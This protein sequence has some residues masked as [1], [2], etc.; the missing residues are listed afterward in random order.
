MTAPPSSNQPAAARLWLFRLVAAMGLPLMVLLALE[1]GLRLGGYGRSASFLI[2][3]ER[4]GFFRSNPEY[5]KLF[6]PG[7]FDLRP[8]NFR[9]AVRKPAN[10]IRVVV[11]GES[12]AQGVP[13][14]LFGFAPQLRAQLR[15]R[16]PRKEIEVINTGI[17][18][19]NSH[20]VYQIACD[21][22][23]IDP[24]LFVVYLGNNEIVGPYGPGCSYLSEMPPLWTIRL[25]VF[26]RATRVGQLMGACLGQL[27]H[28]GMQAE[29]GGMTMF[30]DHAV[31]GDDPRLG[32]VYRNFEANLDDIIRVATAGGARTLLCTVVSNLKDCA[33]F[34]SQHRPGM[35]AADL[36]AWQRAFDRGRIEWRLDRPAKA[37]VSLQEAAQLDPTYADTLFMLGS[38]ALQAGETEN[39]RT[40]LVAAQHWDA[41]RFRP[42]TRI[43][44][45]IRQV[46]SN[47]TGEVRLLDAAVL[48]GS[49]PASTTP[50]AGRELLYEHVHLNWAGNYQ[51]ARL[52][53]EASESTLFGGPDAG[54]PAFLDS[55]G[56]AA[57]LAYS[58]REHHSVLGVVQGIVMAPPFT[59]QLTYCEDGARLVR[60]MAKART[61]SVDTLNLKRAKELVQSAI[62]HDPINPDL[63]KLEENINDALGDIPG[64]WAAVRRA[65]ELQ[66]YYY[67]LAVDEAI[68]LSRLERYGEA[69]NLLK[70]TAAAC[71]PRDLAA[72][73]Q[74]LADLY[75]RTRRWDEGR[76]F[77]DGMIARQPT[78]LKLR[79]IRGRLAHLAGD[80]KS[81]EREFRGIL[82]EE[83][84]N[85]LALESLVSLLNETGRK[86]AAIQASVE[87][88][89]RQPKNQV[90]NFRAALVMEERR[91]D[92]MAVKYYLAAEQSGPVDSAFEIHLAQKMFARGQ[93]DE[94]LLHLGNAKQ[95]S[96][97][98]EN[99]AGAETVERILATLRAQVPQ[100]R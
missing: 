61:A 50:P 20:V 44:E 12:A 92:A 31:A 11:L 45:I 3:D 82:A 55:E 59:N 9:V 33:P 17:V 60:E 2:P 97:Y 36:A 56:C 32:T 99:P 91:N 10:T 67:V 72:V 35:S 51:L 47:H 78:D 80:P 8:Q 40:L 98:E 24:D 74:A 48:M 54:R 27:A 94:A 4:P 14:P 6:M 68:K 100:L 58:A 86:D 62:L 29:W 26:V 21:L 49:D 23:K 1:G 52:M 28:R 96:R 69:E 15:A 41:L 64:A 73:G 88:A 90:N 22:T 66:P 95:I 87:G 13:E 16:F 30:V 79:L 53:A 84:P 85:Q 71:R 25:S 65:R 77:F 46:A 19:I 57:A 70:E 18:A 43:N 81:A 5:L 75:I 63:A 89:D 76:R 34:L 37:R 42:D 93:L 7:G 83:P 39:A 38:L